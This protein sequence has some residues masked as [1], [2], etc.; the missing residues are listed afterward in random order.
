MV[1]TVR[2]RGGTIGGGDVVG[3]SMGELR[4]GGKRE[5]RWVVRSEAADRDRGWGYQVCHLG[6]VMLLK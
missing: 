3:R 1:F 4:V 6:Y 5:G 2:G